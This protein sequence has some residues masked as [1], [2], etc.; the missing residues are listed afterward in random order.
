MLHAKGF[1]GFVE[2]TFFWDILWCPFSFSGDSSRYCLTRIDVRPV[3]D[4][5]NP[6]SI[7]LIQDCGTGF[8]IAWDKKVMMSSFFVISLIL[9]VSP[10]SF[11]DGRMVSH[12]C[13]VMGV[14]SC[15]STSAY[16]IPYT[17]FIF[18]G[19]ERR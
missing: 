12:I 8:H 1:L 17:V 13:S 2:R 11:V 5:E 7:T 15:W 9:F 3:H 4:V 18:G 14:G 16:H 6:A 10:N 19:G